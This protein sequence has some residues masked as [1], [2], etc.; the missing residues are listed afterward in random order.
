MGIIDGFNAAGN[1]IAAQKLRI[2]ADGG[3]IVDED[4]MRAVISV[5]V[6]Q[7]LMGNVKFLADA[8]FAY[9]TPGAGAVSKLYDISGNNNDAT[10]ATGANQPIWTAAQQNGRA[11]LVF[12]GTND[13]LVKTSPSG[14]STGDSAISYLVAFNRTGGTAGYPIVVAYG[15]NGTDK[16]MVLFVY[17]AAPVGAYTY[18]NRGVISA[19]STTTAT[20]NIAKII[21]G[22]YSGSAGTYNIYIDGIFEG[23]AEE[24]GTL[25]LSAGSISIGSGT[26]G[27]QIVKGNLLNCNI[28]NTALTTAQR[29]ALE[30]TVNQYYR[31]Y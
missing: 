24:P 16:D 27:T 29:T 28:F 3:T 21:T 6:Q 1:F 13:R 20:Q 15:G 7:G 12:D 9:K 31:I 30:A 8:N 14:M 25:N 23:T 18:G 4:W 11:G 17:A 19:I 5:L 2:L 10:Q 22:T 26:D